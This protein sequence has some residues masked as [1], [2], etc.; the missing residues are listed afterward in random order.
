MLSMV[1]GANMKRTKRI[2]LINDDPN[3]VVSIVRRMPAGIEIMAASQCEARELKS[4]DADLIILNNDANDRKKAKGPE[5]LGI[6]RLIAPKVPIVYTSYQP[7]WVE[8]EVLH[9][10]DV[11]VVRTDQ[12]PDYLAEKHGIVLRRLRKRAPGKED[13]RISLILSYNPVDNYPE[14]SYGDGK[15]VVLSYD[16][17]AKGKAKVVLEEKMAKIYKSF[18]W[19]NERHTIRNIFIYDGING[20]EMPGKLA[21][22]LAHD[23]RIRV[24]LLAC[25]CEWDRKVTVAESMGLNLRQVECTGNRSLGMIADVIL[26]VKRPHSHCHTLPISKTCI[27]RPADRVW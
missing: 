21:A 15:L 20:G 9:P 4:V 17:L 23:V 1:R 22:T 7:G 13:S 5:T 3:D 11:R 10:K 16:K 26:G 12:L 14:G 8:N 25:K 6:L 2:L 24:N 27:L 19:R 18:S